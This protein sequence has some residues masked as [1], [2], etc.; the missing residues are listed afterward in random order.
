MEK[1]ESDKHYEKDEKS[2]QWVTNTVEKEPEVLIENHVVAEDSV[3]DF[4]MKRG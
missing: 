3:V 4:E 2:A 1:K